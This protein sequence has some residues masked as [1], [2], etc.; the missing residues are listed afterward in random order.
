MRI[1]HTILCISLTLLLAAAANAKIVFSASQNGNSYLYVMDDDGGNITQ[2]TDN[3]YSEWRPRW[4]PNG[5]RIAFVRDTTPNDGSVKPYIY[6]MNSDGT[7]ARQISSHIGHILDL[8]FSPDGTKLIFNTTL[9]GINIINLNAIDLDKI[10][11]NLLTHTHLFHLDWSPDGK[12]IVYVNDDHDVVEKNLWIV[13]VN[14]DNQR[15]WTQPDPERG[16]MHRFNPRWSPDGQQMLYTEMDITVEKKFGKEG[17]VGIS[18]RAAGTFRCIIQN[19]DD[20]ATKTLKIPEHWYPTSVDWMD[21]QKSV[22]FSAYDYDEFEKNRRSERKIYKYDIASEEI[23]FLAEGSNA[24]WHGEALSV[25]PINK[26][27]MRWAELKKSYID[28]Q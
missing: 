17:N 24:D 26:Q 22:L 7:S 4:S 20:G 21:G 14:G 15:A 1:L 28:P 25:S 6:I 8:A 13:D 23:T 2:L 10:E 12:Q 18:I 9:L 19:I 5:R 11:P 3:Q 27:S 16:S